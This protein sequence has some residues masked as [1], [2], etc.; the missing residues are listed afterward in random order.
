MNSYTL[1]FKRK[2]LFSFFLISFLIIILDLLLVYIADKKSTKET[3]I[4][5]KFSK[6]KHF[7]LNSPKNKDI[8]F[9]GSSRTFFHISTNTFIKNNITVYNL[10]VSGAQFEDYPTFIDSVTDSKPKNVVISLSVDKL[11]DGLNVSKFP[12]FK[13]I[14]FYYQI[15]KFMFFQAFKQYLINYHTFLLYSEPIYDKLSSIYEKLTPKPV[16]FKTTN[17]IKKENDLLTLDP[18]INYSKLVGCNVF[19]IKKISSNKTALKCTNGDGILIG[20][21]FRNEITNSKNFDLKEFNNKSI[22]YLKSMIKNLRNNN[23]NIVLILE[24]ILHS[25]YVYDIQKIKNEFRDIKVLDLTNYFIADE[26]W[27][28]NLHLNYKGREQ[29]SQFLVKMYQDQLLEN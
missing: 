18:N 25:K 22:T 9:I 17:T 4:N 23:I 5:D 27:S 20:N 29:Y 1:T 13:E 26:K 8:L 3:F 12:T 14:S 21:H 28:D 6:I 24:P 19:D 2:I 16:L 11:Y 7:E 10:G 15:D